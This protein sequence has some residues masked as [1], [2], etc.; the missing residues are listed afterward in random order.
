MATSDEFMVIKDKQ[1]RFVNN[2]SQKDDRNSNLNLKQSYKLPVLIPVQSCSKSYNDKNCD[3]A[4]YEKSVKAAAIDSF[5]GKNKEDLKN[6]I[7]GSIRNRKQ[8]LASEFVKQDA[9]EFPRQQSDKISEPELSQYKASQRLFNPNKAPNNVQQN[10][11]LAQQ[12]PQQPPHNSAILQQS[13]HPS[14]VGMQQS[15]H[16][17]TLNPGS[18]IYDQDICQPGIRIETILLFVNANRKIWNL[19]KLAQTDQKLRQIHNKRK[20]FWNLN[21]RPFCRYTA[22]PPEKPMSLLDF[23]KE[24]KGTKIVATPLKSQNAI[25]IQKP[26]EEDLFK[27]CRDVWLTVISSSHPQTAEAIENHFKIDNGYK[28]DTVAASLGFRSTEAFL[29][30]DYISYL[31]HPSITKDELDEFGAQRFSAVSFDD[32]TH[33]TDL[34]SESALT[35]EEKEARKEYFKNAKY[36]KMEYQEKAIEM[37]ERLAKV[38]HEYMIENLTDVIEW[39]TVQDEY[40]KKFDQQLSKKVS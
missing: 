40:M 6:G 1:Q 21:L 8:L 38:I 29:L 36:S 32:I 16:H 25:A 11:H 27:I 10:I 3:I 14:T 18:Q 33:I 39:N 5:V 24:T 4:A 26:T 15:P 22:L 13:P 12:R 2:N 17:Q 19:K 30:S 37:R 31:I 7:F 34:M 23:V 28:L 35:E 20:F 9:F